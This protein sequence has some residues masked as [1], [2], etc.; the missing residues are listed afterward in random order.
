MA[1]CLGRFWIEEM[2][3]DNAVIEE[4]ASKENDWVRARI[5]KRDPPPEGPLLRVAERAC[6]MATNSLGTQHSAYAVALQNLGLYYE[7]IENDTP[8]AN[9]FFAQARAV[10][11]GSD[12]PLAYGFYWLGIFHNQVTR[13]GKRAEAALQE[14]LAIQR[15]A[16]DGDDLQLAET[17]IALDYAKDLARTQ[18]EDGN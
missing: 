6:N 1:P 12:L 11:K 13:D 18:T 14:A 15:R 5:L 2:S 10:L 8:K 3:D 16:P 7:V 4:H 9:E 17:M